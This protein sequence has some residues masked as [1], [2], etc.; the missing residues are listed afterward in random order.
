[1]LPVLEQKQVTRLEE[2]VGEF[3]ARGGRTS[4]RRWAQSAELTACRAGMLM[5]GDLDVAAKI[6]SKEP[7]GAERLADV[8]KFWASDVAS[9]L[10]RALGVAIE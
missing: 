10:R 3:I 5:C 9:E 6:L 2:L 7:N 8:E 1:M 4:L